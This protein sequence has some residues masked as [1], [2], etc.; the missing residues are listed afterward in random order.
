MSD[1][2]REVLVLVELMGLS[3][4]EAA[5][6]LG[7]SLRTCQRVLA[8]ARELF[9]RI[10]AELTIEGLQA[11]AS[12]VQRLGGD[13]GFQAWLRGQFAD[14]APYDQIVKGVLTATSRE[15]K[16]VE[17]WITTKFMNAVKRSPE[18]PHSRRP[19][20]PDVAPARR[21][22]PLR[23][24]AAEFRRAGHL[25]VKCV[26]Y[27]DTGRTIQYGTLVSE[28][29]LIGELHEVYDAPIAG[30]GT[31]RAVT[32]IQAWASQRGV[33]PLVPGV[34]VGTV[35]GTAARKELRD[36]LLRR[37]G[38][39]LTTLGPFL[40]GAA[41]ASFLN[42]RATKGV[43]ERIRDD[44]RGGRRANGGAGPGPITS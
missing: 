13:A 35:L 2:Q 41:V 17:R 18:A 36:M 43:G 12:H 9:D 40:A 33:N 15:G 30:S 1:S 16:Q 20:D 14:N 27:V 6:A 42:R 26:P 21:D 31:E 23:M 32:L 25:L 11:I 34:G 22:V 5:E 8:Q 28:L 24:D 19:S 4:K 29:T 10:L 39:N 38:R 37:F 44:L 3:T 7:T